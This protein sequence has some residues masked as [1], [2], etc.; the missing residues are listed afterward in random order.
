MQ[1]HEFVGRVQQHLDQ[2]LDQPLA[3]AAVDATMQALGQTLSA[4]EARDLAAQLPAE[5][6]TAVTRDPGAGPP[7]DAEAFRQR[8]A[9]VANIPAASAQAYADAT[10][11]VL[12]D[13]VSEGETLDVAFQVPPFVSELMAR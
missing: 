5:L 4:V 3:E 7:A 10:L 6:K 12:R 2:P 11:S 9:E 8:V 1:T 13:A